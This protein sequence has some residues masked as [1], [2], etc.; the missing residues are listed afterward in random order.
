MT[1][2]PSTPTPAGWYADPA[3]SPLQRWWDGEAWTDH[4]HDPAAAAPSTT[5]LTAPAGTVV[6]NLWIWLLVAVN[7]IQFVAL[8]F[9]PWESYLRNYMQSSLDAAGS[10]NPY[11]GSSGS[12]A[13][14]MTPEYL[15]LTA[16]GWIVTAVSILF[17]FLDYRGL[18]RSGVPKPFHWAWAFTTLA[19]A[20]MFVYVIGRAVVVKRRTGSGMAPMWAFIATQILAFVVL[21]GV[22]ISVTVKVASELPLR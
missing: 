17:A 14:L 13:L 4:V 12:M 1:N 10:G 22:V 3:G 6:N 20:G 15:A 21:L 2:S 5:S 7:A 9:F 16:S 11:A 8:M 18:I 19:G